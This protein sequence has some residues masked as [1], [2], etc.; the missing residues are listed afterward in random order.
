MG[1][2]PLWVRWCVAVRSSGLPGGDRGVAL[3]LL[4]WADS[5]TGRLWPSVSSIADAAGRSERFVRGSLRRLAAAG[6]I[7]VP[8]GWSDGGRGRTT[9]IE[10]QIPETR[11]DTTGYADENPE[12]GAG[13]PSSDRAETR[14]SA[15]ETRKSTTLNPELGARGTYQEPAYEL[16]EADLVVGGAPPEMVTSPPKAKSAARNAIARVAKREGITPGAAARWIVDRLARYAAITPA[17]RRRYSLHGWLA[18]ECYDAPS[19]IGDIRRQE[20]LD[21]ADAARKAAILAAARKRA[22]PPDVTPDTPFGRAI[23]RSRAR[24][25]AADSLPSDDPKS[26]SPL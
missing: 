2:R 11:N 13:I 26:P 20:H 4:E 6:L 24:R 23:L 10:L 1:D 19:L 15:P 18:D 21:A 22:A 8:D 17:D 3:A 7:A 12:P 16:R 25:E 5:R 9:L 14:K